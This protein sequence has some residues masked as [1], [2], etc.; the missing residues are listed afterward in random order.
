M[1]VLCS[2]PSFVRL[3]FLWRCMITSVWLLNSFTR[4]GMLERTLGS[5]SVNIHV[6]LLKRA[7]GDSAATRTTFVR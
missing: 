2:F 6:G 5:R 1:Y 3:V 4:L 7:S